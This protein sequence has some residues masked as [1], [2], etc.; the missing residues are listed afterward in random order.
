M[1]SD[2]L[3]ARV[4]DDTRDSQVMERI[5]EA[6]PRSKARVA[7]AT[8]WLFFLTLTL[9]RL[10][11]DGLVVPDDAQAI[12]KKI[13]AHE[14]AFRIGFALDLSS[15]AFYIG[16]TVLLYYL[17]KP[18]NRRVS[19]LAAFFNLV[20][21]AIHGF[22]AVFKLAVL[23]VLG[24]GH[25]LSAFNVGQLQ[26]LALLFLKLDDQSWGIA[27][28]FFGAYWLLTSYLIFRSTFLPRILAVLP[29]L[30]GLSWLTHLSPSL[31][32]SLSPGIGIL[33]IFGE[34]SLML[35]LLVM[36]V[37]SQRWIERASKASEP[38]R[39]VKDAAAV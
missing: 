36:G 34:V 12:A 11:T 14:L 21:S 6:S 8:Y 28:V 5:A 26:G 19:L 30:A 7:S 16:M 3:T 2:K 32:N 15:I 4:A 38:D 39:R 17:F 10:L 37:N 13:L 1:N 29:V 33:G 27:L 20:G 23:L 18:V 9:G 31:A 25:Y 22:G 24:G 35:W